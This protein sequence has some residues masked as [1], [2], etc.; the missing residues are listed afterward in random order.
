MYKHSIKSLTLSIKEKRKIK[1]KILTCHI[2]LLF[3]KVYKLLEVLSLKYQQ[4][5]L[6]G[7]AYE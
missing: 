5:S 2:P 6:K 3:L 4:Q 7:N 1:P